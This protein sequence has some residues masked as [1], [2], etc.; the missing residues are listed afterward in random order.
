[1]VRVQALAGW[2]D[3][4]A[5]LAGVAVALE[6]GLALTALRAGITVP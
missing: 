6:G 3:A 2:V 5:A 1:M 4:S